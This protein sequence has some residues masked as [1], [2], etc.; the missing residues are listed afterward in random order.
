MRTLLA[1]VFLFLSRTSLAQLNSI[2][3]DKVTDEAGYSIHGV[4]HIIQDRDGF[5][6]FSH[7]DGITKFDGYNFK[8]YSRRELGT[9]SFKGK[10]VSLVFRDKKQDVWIVTDAGALML[11]DPD[12]DHF[13]VMND[14]VSMIEGN[15]YSFVE[16]H[17]GNF[18]IGSTG[19]GLY[20]I[21]IEKR[22][23][24]NYRTVKD[25][26]TSVNNDFVTALEIDSKR[27]LW[28]GTTNGFCRYDSIRDAFIRYK[29]A[30]SNPTDAYRYRVIRDLL[31]SG[32][33]YIYAGTYGGLHKMDL[34]TGE[35]RHFLHDLAN[36]KSLSHNSIFRLQ[37]DRDGNIWIATYGGGV[38]R[39]NPSTVEFDSWKA[40]MNEPGR[41]HTNNFFTLYFDDQERLWIAAADEGVFL[42]NPHAKKI[43]TIGNSNYDSS[44]IS[45]GWIRNLFQENDSIIWI[46]F[47]GAGVNK[48]NLKTEKVLMRYVNNPRDTTSLGHNAV[49][50]IDKDNYGNI[51]FGL[52]GGGLNKL[53]QRSGKFTRYVF[54]PH[55]N[56]LAN[57]AVSGLLVDDDLIWVATYVSGLDLFDVRN[58]RFYH[59]REDS[60]KALGISFSTTE[61]IIKHDG[62]I[63]FGTH[64]G[65]VVFDK[66][67]KI[68]VK[69]PNTKGDITT[70]SRVRELELRP[71]TEKE[72]LINKD[73]SEVIK[74]KYNGPSDFMQEI[75]W[76]DTI[77]HGET[78]EMRFAA[79]R[80]GNLWVSSGD[81]LNKI[82]L[83]NNNQ[84]TF[85]I[86]NSQT[87]ERRLTGI[88]TASDGKI[89]LTGTNGFNWFYPDE[90]EKDST[91]VRLVLTGLEIFNKPVLVVGKDLTRRDD[92][93][94]SKHIDK[95]DVLE[96]FYHQ[97]FFS[98]RFAA[99][100]FNQRERIQYAYQLE[101]FDRDWVHVGNRRFASYT[102]LDPGTY[103]FKVKATNADGFWMPE[104][105]SIE[106]IIL[107]PFWR[108][109]W[110]IALA[111]VMVGAIIYSIHRYR[112]AQTLK[113]ERLRNKIAS[114]LHDEVG[115]SLTR[116]SI[117]SDLLQNGIE[118]KE[119]KSYLAGIGALS[120]E[121]VSTMSDIVWSI[122]NRNDNF[123]SLILRM[124]D[125]A[126]ELL[127][128]RNIDFE[129]KVVGVTERK[130]LDPALKQNIYLIFKESIHNVVKHSKARRVSV[131]I[132]N[133]GSEF[134]MEIS[135]DGQGFHEDGVNAGNGMRNMKRRAQAIKANFEVRNQLG[136]TISLKREPL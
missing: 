60:L 101:G 2:W 119:G 118:I 115:S 96:L 77:D 102:N 51:W 40:K 23:F 34:Q 63:W 10:S 107:P 31:L 90:I 42:Y 32:D 1:V 88:F 45:S 82:D 11:Y 106:L 13:R 48:Y 123:G 22:I 116:I 120:R 112:V 58:N 64:Q 87:V 111:I 94:L 59:F 26:L 97:N 99:L 92:F 125:F 79:D 98:I 19:G 72:I 57:N 74:I 78:Y 16:D 9:P 76:K 124:K 109:T 18:W 41:L 103:R 54:K 33:G 71:Y 89:F 44:S 127:Q 61:N 8:L 37:Q 85:T 80:S 129:F 95:L 105:R 86:G 69:I 83:R 3:F 7:S 30:N 25:D 108:T 67:K 5:I 117:Y 93:Q 56:S 27:N 36:P 68:F 47:N 126:T 49:I 136:T 114:D 38:N 121:V 50:A 135:D 91:P 122:D 131:V 70:L 15:A 134:R 24:K 132:N 73:V 65:I 130:V 104:P 43:H 52:E 133:D 17:K 35:D 113:V 6:W 14:T 39:F 20:K 110:F 21:N 81:V 84:H 100:A 53:D 4:E 75:L 62:N 55:K 46:G 29:L 66:S 28:I 12:L 128:A